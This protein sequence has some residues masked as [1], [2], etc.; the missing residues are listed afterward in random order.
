M[1]ARRTLYCS[2]CRRDEHH[3]DALVA[4]PAVWICDA[5]VE[6]CRRAIAGTPI[7]SFPGWESLD[8]DALLAALVPAAAAV[9][10]A[11]ASLDE[12]VVVLRGRGVSWARVGAALGVSR[13]AAWQRFG[14]AT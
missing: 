13:Q 2:F 8:D 6:L 5:C 1:A 12:Q 9:S 7:P 4:G 10:A 3:V 14:P 11:E